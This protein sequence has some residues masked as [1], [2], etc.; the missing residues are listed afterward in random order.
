MAE[1]GGSACATAM[2]TQ[3]VPMQQAI[4]HT[5]GAVARL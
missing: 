5:A 1:I 3:G 4:K 2:R